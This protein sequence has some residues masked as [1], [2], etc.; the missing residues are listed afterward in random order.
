VI[1]TKNKYSNLKIFM[2][3]MSMGGAV[4]FNVSLKNSNLVDGNIFMSPS[5]R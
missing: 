5:I 2:C 1:K 3:G 4:A